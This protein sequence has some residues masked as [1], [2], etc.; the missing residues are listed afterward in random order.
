LSAQALAAVCGI[1]GVLGIAVGAGLLIA[2]ERTLRERNALRRW[3][4]E[5]D[6]IALL[7][8]RRSIERPL[9]R[10]H[11]A[12]GAAVSAAAL[13]LLATLWKSRDHALVT[14]ALPRL[15]GARGAEALILAGWALA[16]FALGIG[17]FL[18]MRPSALKG[19]ESVSNRWIEIFPYAG[20]TAGAAEQAL[21]TRA[22]LRA[23]RLTAL[24]LMAAG[25]C[26]L[27]LAAI[28]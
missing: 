21:I 20:K 17:V 26:L 25:I 15:L 27:A 18:L 22:V 7:E 6:L 5:T 13:A 4:L 23:P 11:F 28:G 8:R 19:L 2:P 16:V 14:D 3:F 10:H 24:L 9:Y 1:A 12:F